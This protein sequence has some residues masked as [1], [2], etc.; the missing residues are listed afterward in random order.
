[1]DA[2]QAGADLALGRFEDAE[3]WANTYR[4][5]Q[6]GSARFVHE[7]EGL[8]QARLYLFRSQ[9]KQ[10]WALL[11]ELRLNAES[12]DRKGPLIE[13]LALTA[14]SQYALGEGPLA[15]N[16]LQTAL[17]MAEP[18]GYLHTFIDAGQ[19]MAALLYQALE[20]GVMPDYIG[21][22]LSV[23]PAHEM[24]ADPSPYSS[25]PPQ[26][27]LAQEHLVEPLSERE[28]EVLQLMAG[29]ASNYNIAEALTIAVTTAKKHVSNII[30][31]L[32]V[33]NRTQAVAKGRNLGLCD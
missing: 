9:P 7:I 19:P 32:G 8:I 12:S 21:R 16:T 23:F 24:I 6:T 26:V 29:G 15:V 17:K 20:E 33:D 5:E 30:R 11:D 4:I 3:R 31:K 13:I 27:E 28:L 18:E 10:A 2:G 1:M 25:E 14:L 22:L